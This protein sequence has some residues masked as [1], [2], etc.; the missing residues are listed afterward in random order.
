MSYSGSFLIARPSLLDPNFRQTVVLLLHHSDEG[1]FGLV[2]NRPVKVDDLPFEVFK[3]GPCES[4]GLYL[5]HG[6]PDLAATDETGHATGQVAQG[7][8]IG[9]ADWSERIKDLSQEELS[10][11]RMFA[12]YS[13]WGPGQL[14][15][16]LAEGA[17]TLVPADGQTLWETPVEELWARLRPPAIPQPS[18]N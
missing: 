16:E 4:E 13:G 6:L 17:W 2:L 1:A 15:R 7:I 18:L 9:D 12:G 14:E 3:G 5:L 10:R 8:F 11:V